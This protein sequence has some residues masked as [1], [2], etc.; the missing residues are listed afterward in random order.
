MQMLFSSL[1]KVQGRNQGGL[2]SACSTITFI[3]AEAVLVVSVLPTG[4]SCTRRQSIL[5]RY[6]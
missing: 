4:L 3:V 2:V 5:V 1:V 6:W